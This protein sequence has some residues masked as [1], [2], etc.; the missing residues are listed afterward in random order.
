[1][2]S[3]KLIQ[4][5]LKHLDLVSKD[6]MWKRNT[7]IQRINRFRIKNNWKENKLKKA[8]ISMI[9]LQFMV[10]SLDLEFMIS[11]SKVQ[12]M[13]RSNRKKLTILIK[14]LFLTKCVIKNSDKRNLHQDSMNLNRKRDHSRLQQE[15]LRLL[16]VQLFWM[17]YNI[18]P[19]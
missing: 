7:L 6:T 14:K 17:Q 18:N 15:D 11:L 19:Q 8:V 16:I 1:M 13:I 12:S 3:D 10:K 4:Q 9:M 2:E 5:Q